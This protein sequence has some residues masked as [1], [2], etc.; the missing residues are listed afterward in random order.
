MRMNREVRPS[1]D[2]LFERF[3]LRPNFF[4]LRC[5]LRR[6]ENA[7]GSAFQTPLI[8][9]YCRSTRRSLPATTSKTMRSPKTFSP[10]RKRELCGCSSG[11][12][13]RLIELQFLQRSCR[14]FGI[15]CR[16]RSVRIISGVM[17]FTLIPQEP[18][19]AATT[20]VQIWTPAFAAEYGWAA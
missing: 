10:K 19:W 3:Q 9:A 12:P 17:Q 1:R 20:Q 15:C 6:F 8:A 16:F 11:V 7:N 14:C 18:A 13:N 4:Y 5:S 2:F